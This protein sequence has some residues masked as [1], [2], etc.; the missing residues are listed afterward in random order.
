MKSIHIPLQSGSNAI[1]NKMGRHYTKEFI[2]DLVKKLHNMIHDVGIGVDVMVGFPTEDESN[3]RETYR[4][5]DELDIYYL[6][7]F[8][9]SPR[10]GTRAE[11]MEDDVRDSVKKER[12]GLLRG[13]DAMKRKGFYERFTGKKLCILPEGKIY[14]NN[15]MRGYTENYIPVYIP[16]E[17]SLENNLVNVTIKKIRDSMVIGELAVKSYDHYLSE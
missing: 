5:L 15:Y 6:H 3:F 13:L 1:L 2:D 4:F 11:T 9:F 7:V 8:P 10:Q 14:R 12:V 16:Y 17:K